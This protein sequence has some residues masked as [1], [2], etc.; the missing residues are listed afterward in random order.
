MDLSGN[1]PGALRAPL[2]A[3]TLQEVRFPN[4]AYTTVQEAV[5]AL[6]PGGTLVLTEGTHTG[7]ITIGKPLRIEADGVVLLTARWPAESPV[8]ALVGGADLAV[9]GIAVGH[10]SEGLSLGADARAALTDCVLSDNGRGV[11]ATDSAQI[12]LLRCRLS[13]NE[14]GGIW[15][16]GAA[17]GELRECTFTAN[18]V[19]GVGLGGTATGTIVNCVI[20]ESGWNGGITMRDS[21]QA[22]IEGNTI[23]GNYGAGVA[24]YHGLCIGSGY[25]FTGRI[26]GGG[27]TFGGN[28]RGSV[29]PPELAF[30]AGEWGEFDRRR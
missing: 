11:H 26:S 28:Y 18:A 22:R 20:T 25:V 10:G 23:H 16:W 1:L 4:P 29:C 30:L 8:L 13:R 24:L 27:N 21:A 6:L 3:P 5:D 2:V 17:H 12:A 9:T 14:Q 15:L 7:G 19:C